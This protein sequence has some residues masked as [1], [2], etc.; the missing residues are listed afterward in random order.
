MN[1]KFNESKLATKIGSFIAEI[2]TILGAV[3]FFAAQIK[4]K[5]EGYYV[6][7]DWL[8]MKTYGIAFII[9]GIAANLLCIIKSTADHRPSQPKSVPSSSE[10]QANV[11]SKAQKLLDEYEISN[12]DLEEIEENISKSS[13]Q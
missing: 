11:S 3:L 6:N 13:K 5:E 4:I 1:N 7:N 8:V 10:K 2:L 12:M 9:T